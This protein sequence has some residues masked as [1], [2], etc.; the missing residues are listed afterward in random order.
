M[1]STSIPPPLIEPYGEYEYVSIYCQKEVPAAL[2][3]FR[4]DIVICATDVPIDEPHGR[5]SEPTANLISD[6][7]KSKYAPK[8]IIVHGTQQDINSHGFKGTPHS[9]GIW[10]EG[11]DMFKYDEGKDKENAERLNKMIWSICFKHN[12]VKKV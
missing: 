6:I 9:A 11:E 3:A 5:R 10:V 2:A 1:V 12:L 8:A 7:M 4:P